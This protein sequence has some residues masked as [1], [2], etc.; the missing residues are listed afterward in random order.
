M[1]NKILLSTAFVIVF[2]NVC[3][4]NS[5]ESGDFIIQSPDTIET[6]TTIVIENAPEISIIKL[7]NEGQISGV[8]IYQDKENITLDVGFGT[9]VITKEEIK[10]IEIPEGK[11]KEVKTKKWKKHQKEITTS[12]DK[13]E[14]AK[15]EYF[16][17]I[18]ENIRIEEEKRKRREAAEKEKEHRVKFSGSRN[19]IVD[20]IISDKIQTRLVLDTGATSVVLPIEMVQKLGA[21]GAKYS[22]KI[23]VRLADGSIRQAYAIV[24]KSVQIGDIKAYNVEAIA[25]NSKGNVG[26]L[27]MSFLNRY[28]LKMDFE[29]RELVFK[30]K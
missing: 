26:L 14:Q 13:K 17:R 28:H 19:L 21:K 5:E 12:E 7:K 6:E 16:E 1:K 22:K 25:I 29:N 24:L 9:V 11:E 4:I 10:A 18:Q 15:L 20:A 30:E 2:F 3:S 23:K 27:G 8:I